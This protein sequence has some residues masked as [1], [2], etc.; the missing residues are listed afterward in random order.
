MNNAFVL[1]RSEEEE[2]KSSIHDS[3]ITAFIDINKPD[4]ER[5]VIT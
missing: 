1:W 5:W 2:A 4:T 3:V